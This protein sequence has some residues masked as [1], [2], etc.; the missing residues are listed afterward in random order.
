MN[1]RNLP[2]VLGGAITLHFFGMV[3]S[4]W[5]MDA[6]QI[7][8]TFLTNIYMVVFL[9]PELI[10]SRPWFGVLGRLGL[11]E[12]EWWRMPSFAGL[13]LVNFIYVLSLAGLGFGLRRRG[14]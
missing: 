2:F 3:V 14:R 9:A 5:I 1:L 10:W 7:A 4:G 8:D 12:G 13:A 6:A 11:M